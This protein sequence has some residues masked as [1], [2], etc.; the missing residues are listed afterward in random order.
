MKKTTDLK[1][2]T[3]AEAKAAQLTAALKELLEGPERRRL[4]GYAYQL[5]QSWQQA[6]ELVQEACFRALKARAQYDGR[7]EL[8]GWVGRIV[9]NAYFDFTRSWAF[10]MQVADFDADGEEPFSEHVADGIAGPLEQLVRS[11]EAAMV[12]DAVLGLARPQ[13]EAVTLCDLNA[14]SYHHAAKRLGIPMGTLR[15]RLSRGLTVLRRSLAA[16]MGGQP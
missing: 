2:G 11:D 7:E 8:S 14:L 10:K 1:S 16:T 13:R 15:S 9:R 12:A 6:E 3:R 5:C 4:V